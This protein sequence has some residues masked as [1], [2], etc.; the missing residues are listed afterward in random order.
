MK[1]SAEADW[2][3]F[4]P[5]DATPRYRLIWR[6][7]GPEKVGKDYFALTAPGPIA[8]QS[9]D[10]GLE[11]VVERFLRP[12]LG[13]KVVRTTEYEFSARATQSEARDLWDQFVEDYR[14]ALRVARTIIWDT[15]TELWEVA[16]TKEFEANDVGVATDAPKNY[17]PLNN[18]YR[19][20]I[21][22]AYDAS[23]NLCLIQKVKEK[24]V[25]VERE[26]RD[27]NGRKT[28]VLSPQASGKYEPYGF[29]EAGYIVQANLRHF[30]TKADGFGIEVLNCRQNMD[31]AGETFTQMQEDSSLVKNFSDFAQLVFPDSTE[32]D[33]M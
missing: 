7:F 8:I 5:I 20:L 28:T 26:K 21:Q 24:W 19:D 29:K 25:T 12:P 1:K 9:F 18:E 10:I 16:R 13:P 2:G 14:T 23:V 27:E 6:S 33:W 17:T 31:V 15:E 3:R 22:E 4:K 11:G 30:W 32:N